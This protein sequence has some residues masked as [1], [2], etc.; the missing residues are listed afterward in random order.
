MNVLEETNKELL[1]FNVDYDFN[2]D[3]LAMLPASKSNKLQQSQKQ[4]TLRSISNKEVFAF[5]W[6]YYVIKQ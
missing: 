5:N 4:G 1:N 2:E 3:D 6:Y